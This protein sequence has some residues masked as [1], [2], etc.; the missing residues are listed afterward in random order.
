MHDRLNEPWSVPEMARVAH[1]SERNFRK[2][3]RDVTGQPP[4]QFYNQLRLS[5]ARQL[6]ARRYNVAQTADALGFSSP[7][8]LSREFKAF[9]GIAPSKVR[10]ADQ[11]RP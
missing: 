4:K 2:I 6:L 9:Y 7:Y 11:R 1:M 3:F 8:H 5:F 10:L